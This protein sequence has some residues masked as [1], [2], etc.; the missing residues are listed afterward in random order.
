MDTKISVKQARDIDATNA[1][2]VTV[3][4]EFETKTYDVHT[5]SNGHGL[6]IDGKQVEGTSQFS[7]GKNPASAIRRYFTN[8]N[9]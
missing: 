1:F 2:T 5:N 6:W 8:Y 3:Q 7:A 4:D 9:G